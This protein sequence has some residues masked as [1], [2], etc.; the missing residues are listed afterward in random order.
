MDSQDGHQVEFVQ[1]EPTTRCNFICGFCCGRKMPM[2]SIAFD[3]FCR[4]LDVF[5][6]V[7]HIELQGEGEPLLHGDFFKMARYAKEKGVKLSIITNGSLL[8]KTDVI[9]QLIELNFE[10]VAVSVESTNPREFKRI[11]GGVFEEVAAGIE[12]LIGERNRRGLSRPVV[13]FA[14]TVLESTVEAYPEIVALYQKL[15]MDGGITTQ[16]LQCMESYVKTYEP[17]MLKELVSEE[18]AL[19]FKQLREKG[20]EVIGP[21]AKVGFYRELYDYPGPKRNTCPWLEKGVYV[22]ADGEMSPCPKIK[23][24]K[25]HSY[26]YVGAPSLASMAATRNCMRGQLLRGEV[27]SSCAGCPEAEPCRGRPDSSN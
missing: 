5:P 17:A 4:T 24:S 26:G 23:E 13:G 20:K 15:G 2:R 3:T 6:K 25:S 22:A 10:K 12:E 1:I 11:R 14:V 9:P 27:P 21:T 16:L 18:S 19:R 7:R 8:R